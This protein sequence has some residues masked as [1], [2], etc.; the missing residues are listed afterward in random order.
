MGAVQNGFASQWRQFAGEHCGQMFDRSVHRIAQCLTFAVTPRQRSQEVRSFT[1][2]FRNLRP[3]GSFDRALQSLCSLLKWNDTFL[4]F[5]VIE[6]DL[7]ISV[8]QH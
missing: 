7:L 8:L 6:S 2:E 1:S 3:G 4:R 5:I